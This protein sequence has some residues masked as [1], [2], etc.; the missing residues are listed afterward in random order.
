MNKLL[1]ILIFALLP[2][3][4][5]AHGEH[6]GAMGHAGDP[7]KVSTTIEVVM[8][9][10]MR[11]A[12]DEIKVKAGDTIRFNVK[13]AGQIPHEMVIGSMSE[14]KGHAEE[15]RKMPGLQHA[16]PNMIGLK[17][18]QHGSIVWKFDKPG[19]VDFACLVPGHMEA[20]MKGKVEVD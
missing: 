16:E 5:L 1:S 20:G 8:S 18:G 9:D 11:F 4:A 6:D 13:N 7:A 3:L 12:P 19:T 2:G 15:M 17:P 10:N 14:L